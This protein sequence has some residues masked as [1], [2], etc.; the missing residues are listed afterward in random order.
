MR[1]TVD[2]D[3]DVLAAA[4]AIARDERISLGAAVSRL[5]KRGISGQQVV[6]SGRGFP[7]IGTDARKPIT[8]HSVNDHRDE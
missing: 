2:L 8:L 1:T 5:A 3:D 7:I 4:R 6:A